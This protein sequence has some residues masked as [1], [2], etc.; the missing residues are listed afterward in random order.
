MLGNAKQDEALNTWARM[1]QGA[2]EDPVHFHTRLLT[3]A[4]LVNK[5]V[6]KEL[7]YSRLYRRV[8]NEMITEYDRGHTLE[9]MVTNAQRFFNK[10]K[11]KRE[12]ERHPKR[13]W[14]P[15]PDLPTLPAKRPRPPLTQ[16]SE[17]ERNRR[18]E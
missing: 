5:S 7:F 6:N 10:L 8:T 12:S 9:E 14:N 17:A 18:K 13:P 16:V 11:R 1:R 2:D 3:H 4:R 15:P